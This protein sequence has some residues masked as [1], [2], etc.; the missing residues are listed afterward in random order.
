MPQ[1]PRCKGDLPLLSKICPICGFVVDGG[2]ASASANAQINALE[3]LVLQIKGLPRPT[4]LT[5]IKNLLG[6]IVLVLTVYFIMMAYITDAMSFKVLGGVFL[7]LLQYF[8]GKLIASWFKPSVKNE[9]RR[10]MNEFE[11]NERIVRRTFGSD[12]EVA[13]QINELT[14]EIVET[15]DERRQAN[16]KILYTWIAIAAAATIGATVSMTIA[17]NAAEQRIAEAEYGRFQ[18]D[19]DTFVASTDNDEHMGSAARLAI[20]KRMIASKDMES[21]EKFFFV[22]CSGRVGDYDCAKT[23][24]EAYIAAREYTEAT[25]FVE[26]TATLRYKSDFAK[27]KK[28]L[29]NNGTVQ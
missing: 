1:C 12:R 10:I 9:F 27:L 23:I 24:V 16:R 20:V 8:L 7:V 21:A 18:K 4:F 5:S 13:R 17:S 14:T 29:Q 22:Y 15:V 19:V 28:L 26:Q 3:Q 25:R 6:I 2:D 11:Y